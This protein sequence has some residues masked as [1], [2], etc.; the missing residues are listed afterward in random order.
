MPR[1]NY[2]L[3]GHAG[4]SLNQSANGL[5]RDEGSQQILRQVSH[6]TDLANVEQRVHDRSTLHKVVQKNAATGTRQQSFEIPHDP[7]IAPFKLAATMSL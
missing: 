7:R 6:Q 1:D 5:G 4:K 2:I 3:H